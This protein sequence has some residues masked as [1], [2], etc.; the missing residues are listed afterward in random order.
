VAI[1]PELRVFQSLIDF[2][3][4]KFGLDTG[5]RFGE[6]RHAREGNRPSN[7]HAAK[8]TPFT[9]IRAKKGKAYQDV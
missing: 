3:S 9:L 6:G 8:T 1:F 7:L 4:G 5:R 2:P